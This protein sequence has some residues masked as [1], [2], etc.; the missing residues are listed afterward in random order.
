[1]KNSATRSK[2]LDSPNGVLQNPEVHRYDFAQHFDKSISHCNARNFCSGNHG[3]AT[4]AHD[5]FESRSD[6]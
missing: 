4:I 6:S 2:R 1:L 5:T 3:T